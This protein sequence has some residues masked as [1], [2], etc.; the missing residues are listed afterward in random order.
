MGQVVACKRLKTMENR[1]LTVRTK[2]WSRSNNIWKPYTF[3]RR[4]VFPKDN[5]WAFKQKLV[6]NMH[7]AVHNLNRSEWIT[8][9]PA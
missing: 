7:P 3:W 5:R 8:P 1:Q 4:S 6:Q 9:E 2:T